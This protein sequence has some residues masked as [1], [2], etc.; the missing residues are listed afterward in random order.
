MKKSDAFSLVL[1]VIEDI[2][3]QTTYS[4]SDNAAIRR[5][6]KWSDEVLTQL[7]KK[8]DKEVKVVR[9]RRYVVVQVA[10]CLLRDLRAKV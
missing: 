3:S 7:E 9:A 10:A 5:D 4:T 1:L 6:V 8:Q 2:E